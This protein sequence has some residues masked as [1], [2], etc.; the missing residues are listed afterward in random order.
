MTY[1]R[2]G[3]LEQRTSRQGAPSP[4]GASPRAVAAAVAASAAAVGPASRTSRSGC[5]VYP[6]RG[7]SL[8]VRV[9]GAQEDREGCSVPCSEKGQQIHREELGGERERRVDSS[10]GLV[11]R[12]YKVSPITKLSRSCQCGICFTSFRQTPSWMERATNSNRRTERATNGNRRIDRSTNGNRGMER[13]ANRRMQVVNSGDLHG[14]RAEG[15]SSW[16]LEL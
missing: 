9:Y 2:R 4:C 16:E 5:S 10:M 11:R 14:T 15:S 13:A 3:A 8:A 1:W 12:T 6:Q 7:L